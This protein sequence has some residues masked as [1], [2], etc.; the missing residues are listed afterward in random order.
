MS[1]AQQEKCLIMGYGDIGQRLSLRLLSAG[2]R[3]AAVSRS[4][5][6][7]PAS[8]V[9]LRQ[10]DATNEGEISSL[11]KDDYDIVVV[12]LTPD[13]YSDEAYRH[14]YVRSMAAITRV[15][16]QLARRPRLLLFV[17]STSVY[18]QN[19]GRWVDETSPTE[20]CGYAGKRLLEAEH[21]LLGADLGGCV[22]RF[23]GIYGPGRETLLGQVRAGNGCQP[24]PAVYTNRIHA[25]DC[26]GVLEHLINYQARG[27]SLEPI[28]LANDCEPVPLW[29][30]Q[31][32]L[33]ARL[34]LP[35]GHLQ[36]TS[37]NR[38]AGSKR[39]DNRRL[40]DTG[41]RFRYPSFREGYG[42]LIDTLK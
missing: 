41:Y 40:L 11:F 3:V 27:A 34:G 21:L 10:C 2:Y 14:T 42:E 18:G 6:A 37:H 38:R 13:D 26:A 7:E 4:A 29:E 5:R 9:E 28:Y 17:S 1:T 33:A 15:L 36:P 24:E 30:L 35:I 23:S 32:W 8:I 39:C 31:Q 12:T 20:P 25:D 16:T 19:D 22:V